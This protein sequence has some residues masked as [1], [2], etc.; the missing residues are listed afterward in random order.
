MDFRAWI[1]TALAIW[2]DYR[3]SARTSQNGL[4]RQLPG[5]LFFLP[6]VQI[7][8]FYPESSIAI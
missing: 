2:H 1:V 3:E 7:L 5:R 4:L 6:A 8:N